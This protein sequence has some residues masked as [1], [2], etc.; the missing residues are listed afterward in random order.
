MYSVA[1]VVGQNV[2]EICIYVPL[3]NLSVPKN[4]LLSRLVINGGFF[5][6][7]TERRKSGTESRIF[8][9]SGIDNDYIIYTM[10]S[11][12]V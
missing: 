5:C 8:G 3:P 11:P 4:D 6:P 1:Q 10:A 2:A 9:I 7:G 12:C